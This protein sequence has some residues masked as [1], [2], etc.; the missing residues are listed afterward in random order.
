M[1]AVQEF[2]KIKNVDEL[3]RFLKKYNDEYRAIFS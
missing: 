2:K 1:E 3:D